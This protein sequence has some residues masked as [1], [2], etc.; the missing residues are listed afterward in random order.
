[1]ELPPL[2][3]YPF[4]SKCY[5]VLQFGPRQTKSV[6]KLVKNMQ[7]QI[8]LSMQQR[9]ICTIVLIDTF[10]SIQWLY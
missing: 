4:P 9:L 10:Y 2:K 5:L 8:I 1:M 7:I 3:E 6:F